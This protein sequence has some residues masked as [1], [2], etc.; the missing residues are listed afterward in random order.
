M[1]GITWDSREVRPGWLYVALPGERVDGHQFVE[2]ALRAGAAGALV[3]DGPSQSCALLARELGAAIIEVPNTASAITDLRPGLA[4]PLAGPRHRADRLGGQD[5]HQEPHART[6]APPTAAWWPP[7]PTRTTSWA[8]PAHC[9]TPIRRRPWSS[10]RW[11]CAA[12]GR[13]PSC[14]IS[15]D[16]CGAL[17]P[18]W[19]RAT[20]SFWAA[21]RT[22]RGPSPSSSRPCPP[23]WAAPS[24]TWTT[25][26]PPSWPN[27]DACLSAPWPSRGF[28]G[29]PDAALRGVSSARAPLAI[30]RSG[31]RTCRWTPRAGRASPCAPAMPPTTTTAPYSPP[32]NACPARSA[33][34]GAHNVDNACAAAS[35]GFA[36]GLDLA[37]IAAALG[38]VGARAGPPGGHRRPRRLHGHQRR[39]QREPRFHARLARD[40]RRHGRGRP[41]HR[42]ARRHGGAGRASPP[43][44]TRASA[45]HAAALPS[46]PVSCAWASWRGIIADRRGGAPAWTPARIS[47]RRRRS[48]TRSAEL[49][50]LRSSRAT[51]CW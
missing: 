20:S 26:S 15:C 18:T 30:R 4:L 31:P 45:A 17:S 14:A 12:A 51:P 43:P 48:P 25:I 50:V 42:R 9:S 6:C 27:A 33:C 11:A 41:A 47:A 37:T 44:A 36:L 21:G 2:A 10:L 23:A 16:R 29:H 7:R 49:D 34:T 5:H 24:P 19:A 28:A 46:R 40:L 22:S 3:T 38:S 13:S 39:L 35:V 8:F 32:W 1:T